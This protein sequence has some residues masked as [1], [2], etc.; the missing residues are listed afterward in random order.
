MIVDNSPGLSLG[1]SRVSYQTLNSYLAQNRVVE[2][3]VL[4]RGWHTLVVNG[5]SYFRITLRLVS[6]V[7]AK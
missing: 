6:N 3:T 1:E 7:A 5:E 4:G 2:A